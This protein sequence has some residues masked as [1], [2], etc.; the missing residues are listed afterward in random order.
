ME[1]IILEKLKINYFMAMAISLLKIMVPMMANGKKDSN[2]VLVK[3]LM[4][5]V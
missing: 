3:I 2:M 1:T 4:L 5:M